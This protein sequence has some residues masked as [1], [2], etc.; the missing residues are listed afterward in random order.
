MMRIL[1]VSPFNDEGNW[2]QRALEESG[3]SLQRARSVPDGTFLAAEESFDVVIVF[4]I[5]SSTFN[6]LQDT[7]PKIFDL[8]GGAVIVTIL[9]IRACAADRV[10]ILRAGADAC[11]NQ[12]YSFEELRERIEALR[13]IS[14]SPP[15]SDSEHSGSRLDSSRREFVE[16]ANRVPLSRREYLFLERLFRQ[17]NSPIK[18]EDLIRYAWPE[19]EEVDPASVNLVVTKLRRK[20]E[21]NMLKTHIETVNRFGYRL[22]A[23]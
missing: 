15:V 20:F 13:R 18:R 16:G 4:A 6:L 8:A 11:F 17:I 7:L 23:E 14:L 22:I 9:G 1:L 2:L 12:P 3:Y 21:G 5:D 10:K 19:D